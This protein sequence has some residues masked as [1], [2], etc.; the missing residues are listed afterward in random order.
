MD[1]FKMSL[2]L[3]SYLVLPEK[4]KEVVR[5]SARQPNTIEMQPM[6][7]RAGSETLR[8]EVGC[9]GVKNDLHKLPMSGW[10]FVGHG[11]SALQETGG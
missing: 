6:M 11:L 4:V 2:S 1:F 7:C 5:V 9:P 3:S 10:R 8:K